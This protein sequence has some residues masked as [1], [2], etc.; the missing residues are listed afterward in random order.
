MWVLLI[1]TLGFLVISKMYSK[2]AVT[3]TDH[4]IFSLLD[5]LI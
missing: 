5:D 1:Y 2:L 3:S 4:V